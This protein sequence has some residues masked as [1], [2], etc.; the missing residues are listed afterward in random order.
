MFFAYEQIAPVPV[1][2]R[3]PSTASHPVIGDLFNILTLNLG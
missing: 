2:L 3:I 1:P